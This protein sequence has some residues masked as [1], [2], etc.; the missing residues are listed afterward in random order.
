MKTLT[1]INDVYYLAISLL[2]ALSFALVTCFILF[3]RLNEIKAA[4]ATCRSFSSYGEA[5]QAFNGGDRRLDH[6]KNGYPCESLI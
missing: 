1:F 3:I 2:I 5:L 4:K 6:N